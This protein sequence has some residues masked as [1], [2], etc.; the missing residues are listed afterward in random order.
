MSVP[1]SLQHVIDQFAGA[2]SSLRLP[3]LLEYAQNLPPLPD[4]LAGAEDRFE[5]VEECQTP[6][7]LASEVAD[8]AVRVWFD[9]PEEAPTT[10]GFAS[11]LAAGL[12]GRTVDEVLAVP[13]DV[14]GRLGL[15]DLISPLRLRGMEGMLRR[16]QR[17]VRDA[18]A[19]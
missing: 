10:R 16:L 6:L 15:T 4:A 1:S 2:P 3:L 9:A 13:T 11:I 12:D 8:G 7:F 14:A 17:Q 19:A 18:Q 5:K